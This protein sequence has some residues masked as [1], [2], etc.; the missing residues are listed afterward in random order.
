MHYFGSPNPDDLDRS[1]LFK[2]TQKLVL[3]D[4]MNQE[5]LEASYAVA[6]CSQIAFTRELQVLLDASEKY[7]EKKIIVS[8]CHP[9]CVAVSRILVCLKGRSLASRNQSS[10]WERHRGTSEGLD[11][12]IDGWSRMVNMIGST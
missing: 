12:T 8:S 9:G 7:R 10:I 5:Q 6:K 1:Q 2:N 4:P 11:K 3:G